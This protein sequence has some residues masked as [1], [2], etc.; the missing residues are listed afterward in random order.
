MKK[1]ICKIFG[2]KLVENLPWKFCKRC[3]VTII[4]YEIDMGEYKKWV[5]SSGK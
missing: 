2:H 1:L 4:T 5:C 3:K